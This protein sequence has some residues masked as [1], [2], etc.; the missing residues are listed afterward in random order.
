ML[1]K[2]VESNNLKP[3]NPTSLPQK[4]P[5][6]HNLNAYCT[7]HQNIGHLTNNCFRLRHTIQDLID[8]KTIPV[9]PQKPN[10]V[11]NPLPKHSNPQV[12]NIDLE[13]S[14]DPSQYIIPETQPKPIVEVLTG[15]A[16]CMIQTLDWVFELRW[17]STI[18][19]FQDIENRALIDGVWPAPELED[20]QELENGAWREEWEERQADPFNGYS[21]YTLFLELELA[22]EEEHDWEWEAE[23]VVWH[24]VEDEDPLD[25]TTLPLLFNEEEVQQGPDLLNPRI[26]FAQ[27]R[28]ETLD[29]I[30]RG[31]DDY[32]EYMTR[33]AE[34]NIYYPQCYI[35]DETLPQPVVQNPDE[36][37]I[38]VLNYEDL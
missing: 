5:T 25:V 16:I 26:L 1:K 4:I 20:V 24:Q 32:Y 7:Y 11:S 29:T 12:N 8:N 10:T 36:P 22:D 30:T 35:V 14:F 19:T 21:L 28:D 17:Q 13:P 31:L 33:P 6:S 9:P 27:F 2:L 38:A 37:H 18:E 34:Q 3:L 15:D 23:L